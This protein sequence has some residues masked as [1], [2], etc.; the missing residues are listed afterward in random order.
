MFIFTLISIGIP[1]R[2]STLL[3]FVVQAYLND[4][5]NDQIITRL[6]RYFRSKLRA[7]LLS[8]K[9]EKI[10]RTRVNSREKPSHR[11]LES[12]RASTCVHISIGAHRFLHALLL[13]NRMHPRAHRLMVQC[14]SRTES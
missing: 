11:Q 5:R 12:Q 13:N 6:K 14:T 9:S 2:S 8:A 7:A 3:D 10:T 4:Q 1:Y